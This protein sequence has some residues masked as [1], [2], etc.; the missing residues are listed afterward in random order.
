ML[1]ESRTLRETVD[2]AF[3]AS[4]D[5]FSA[6]YGVRWLRQYGLPLRA[7]GGAVTQSPLAS[8]EAEELTGMPCLGVERIMDGTLRETLGS[9]R[10]PVLNERDDVYAPG[11]VARSG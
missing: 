4:S 8:Q 1:L 7:I 10:R 11:A 3:F 9:G 2:H 6:E 5:S